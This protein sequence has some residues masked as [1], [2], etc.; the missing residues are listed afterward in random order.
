VQDGWKPINDRGDFGTLHPIVLSRRLIGEAMLFRIQ[1]HCRT[2]VVSEDFKQ[3]IEEAG[4]LGQRF[5]LL[6][7]SD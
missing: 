4:F 2:I 6:E 3:A 1:G 7:C 5:D